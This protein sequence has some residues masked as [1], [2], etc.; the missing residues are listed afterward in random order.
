MSD[1]FDHGPV[2]PESS[3]EQG[4]DPWQRPAAPPTWPGAGAPDAPTE[5]LSSGGPEAWPAQDGPPPATGTSG[6]D[7]PWWVKAW[8]APG[9]SGAPSAPGASGAPSGEPPIGPPPMWQPPVGPPPYRPTAPLSAPPP[10]GPPR[11]RGPSKAAVGTTLLALATAL[12]GGGV[13]AAIGVN[14]ARPSPTA[15]ATSGTST[16]PIISTQ[17]S[18]GQTTIE[19]VAA[20]IAPIVVSI[21]ESSPTVSG[22]GSGVIIRPDGYI[23]TN[24][25]VV[26]AVATSGGTLTVTLNDGRQ[27]PAT[28]VGRDPSS[29]LAVIKVNGLGTLPAAR[30]GNSAA[31]R[32]GQTVLAF[33]SPLGLQGTVTEGIV[34]A[35]HRPVH[36]GDPSVSDT[37]AVIDAIQ[38]DAPINPGN[39][40]GPLVDTSGQVIGID[41]AIATLGTS[42]GGFPFG[43]QQQAGNIGLGFAIPINSAANVASQ[44]IATG[45]AVHAQL[46]VSAADATN[47][48]G[49]LIQQVLAGSGAARAGLQP[50]DVITSF[51]GQQVIDAD[52]LVVAVRA[53]NPGDTVPLTYVRNGVTR[54][55][56][57]TLGSVTD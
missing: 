8:D 46:G 12:I 30:L 10:G 34:S 9:A 19:A 54:T 37:N 5:I 42:A 36:T 2:D 53:H 49:A 32:V 20:A 16:T 3:P 7:G 6:P 25:H 39:S 4:F 33:G 1:S 41:S 14:A 40:G 26:S 55:V 15:L 22:T 35:L 29:D 23:L 21:D 13:G 38:T 31:L 11:R 51:G 44:L 57:V 17:G 50:G 27:A 24:N 43:Q 18:S 52:T 48:S 56:T 47:E 28:I 45:H